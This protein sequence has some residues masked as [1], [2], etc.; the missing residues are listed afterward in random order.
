MYITHKNKTKSW[1]FSNP[2]KRE[3]KLNMPTWK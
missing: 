1:F 2:A 3:L